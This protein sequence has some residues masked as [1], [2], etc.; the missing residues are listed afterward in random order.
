MPAL[1]PKDEPLPNSTVG[2]PGIARVCLRVNDI[3][4]TDKDEIIIPATT[5]FEDDGPNIGKP[6]DQ[7]GA[8]KSK[9]ASSFPAQFLT[10][11][12]A[13]LWEEQTVRRSKGT[14]ADRRRWH[15]NNEAGL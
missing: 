15:R 12:A 10:L 1:P 14:N 4:L 8:M 6:E 3:H 2:S 5:V 9:R 11:T 13:S 7:D